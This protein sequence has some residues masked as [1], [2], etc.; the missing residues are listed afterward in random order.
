MKKL[1]FLLASAAAASGIYVLASDNEPK[2]LIFGKG[3]QLLVALEKNDKKHSESEWRRNLE[4]A[5]KPEE[6]KYGYGEL[7]SLREHTEGNF[8]LA[9]YDCD[10]KVDWYSEFRKG[11]FERNRE[12]EARFERADRLFAEGKT[13]ISRYVDLEKLLAEWLKEKKK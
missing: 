7:V 3:D 13:E 2:V 8:L 4:C 11:E 1:S 6:M 9:D 5:S 10:G 12:N